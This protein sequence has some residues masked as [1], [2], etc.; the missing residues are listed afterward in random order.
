MG[1]RRL[2]N[3]APDDQSKRPQNQQKP[4]SNNT[5]LNG[6]SIRKGEVFRAQRRT[7]ENVNLRASQHM[8][9]VPVNKS[10]YNGYGGRQ[11]SMV[12]QKRQPKTQGPVL[13]VMPIGGLGEMGIGKNMMAIEYGNDI[14]VIDMGFLFPGEGYPGINYIVPDIT[15]L[16]ENKDKVRAIVF[17]HGHLDHIGAARHLLAKLEAP[18][19]A[20]KFTMAMVQRTMEESDGSY[21]PEYIEMNPEEHERV[22]ISEHFNLELVR[23]CHSIPDASAVVLRTP[24]GVLI[25][26]G[27]WRFEENPIDGVKFD[28]E[29]LTEIATKEGILLLMNESTNCEDEGTHQHGENDIKESVGQIF[30]KYPN[31]RI[32]LST[33]SSQL[34]RLQSIMEEAS[35]SGRKVAIAGYSMIQNIEVALR[36]GTIKVPKDTIMKM[37]DIVKMPDGKVVILC[38]GSQGEFSAVLNRIA[39]GSHKYLKAKNS[40]VIVFSSSAIPGNEKYIVRTVDGLM[41]EGSEV[42]RDRKTHLHGIGRIHLSGHGYYDDHVKLISALNPTYYMPIHGEFHMLVHNAEL[43]EKE[44]GIRKDNIFV[45]DSGDVIE[46]T[47]EGVAKKTGR[48][49]VG[50]VMYDDSGAIVSEVVLKDRIHMANEGMFVV[51]LTVQRGSGRLLTSPDIISRGFIYLRDSEEL[52]GLIRQ[53][54]K[55]KVARSFGGKKI[56][57]DVIK[58]EL[59][60][61]I[62]HI[63]YDQTRRTPIVIPVINE[64]GGGG[65]RPDGGNRQQQSGEGQQQQQSQPQQQRDNRPQPQQQQQQRPMPRKFPPRQLPDSEATVPRPPTRPNAY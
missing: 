13:K 40:D 17:T 34:H 24:V 14:V 15:Y 6:T 42:I 4:K 30:E 32:V 25:D 44:C 62:T 55:Q 39:S 46:I 50:G 52:M 58:K 11:F 47:P 31:S 60:D 27:D 3:A 18:V 5:V 64:I 19:Y 51:V 36:T 12:D 49:P 10:T 26:T 43:A 38:T 54:L 22:Q 65:Q 23:V 63:L 59:K 33:F 45:C 9:N 41:R 56:D 35:A 1:Q 61:E 2:S 28:L 57:M 7:S 29:R 53:Y 21:T 48:I 20:S 37:E 16:E 8:I